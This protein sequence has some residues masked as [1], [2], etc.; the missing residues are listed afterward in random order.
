[1]SIQ[2]AERQQ[3]T[4]S[5]HELKEPAG[6]LVFTFV[7]TS[8]PHNTNGAPKRAPQ[9]VAIARR[10]GEH[11]AFDWSKSPDQPETATDELEKEATERM[12]VRDEWI[13]SVAALVDQVDG[14]VDLYRMPAYDDI[15]SLYH[16]ENRWN[17]HYL[18][19]GAKSAVPIRE[20][21]AVPLSREALEHV[22]AEMKRH[23]A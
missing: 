19:A 8:R 11:L 16:Y 2:A 9:F 22:V 4:V 14:V 3:C 1:M 17:V 10:D 6:G 15:A 7:P 5:I 13:D 20:A 18:V 12:R 23:A 21:D